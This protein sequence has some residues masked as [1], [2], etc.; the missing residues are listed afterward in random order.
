M[1]V[2]A[3]QAVMG[4][5]LLARPSPTSITDLLPRP[6]H[7]WLDRAVR[8]EQRKAVEE[9]P[10]SPRTQ[11]A[12]EPTKPVQAPDTTPGQACRRRPCHL[13]K[14]SIPVRSAAKRCRRQQWGS[15]TL[16]V[17]DREPRAKSPRYAGAHEAL[18]IH[19]C[20]HQELGHPTGI[21]H[22][23]QVSHNLPADWP[24][25][26]RSSS[27]G[28]D[29]LAQSLTMLC[30]QRILARVRCLHVQELSTRRTGVPRLWNAT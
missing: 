10:I 7:E 26:T 23:R 9:R 8:Q 29:R 28:E 21:E 19:L 12:E 6:L 11:T 13:P 14:S 16:A 2:E 24:V 22:C 15:I 3:F 17:T 25:A 30:R 5:I 18:A 4:A 20:C 1:N 27:T